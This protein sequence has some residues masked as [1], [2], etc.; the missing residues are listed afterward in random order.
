MPRPLGCAGRRKT[1]EDAFNQRFLD[2]YAAFLQQT[3]WYRYPFRRE[4]VR[5]WRETPWSFRSPVRSAERRF[6]LSLEY[7][8]KALYAVAIGALA[9]AAPAD[10]SIRTVLKGPEEPRVDN[11][12]LVRD[13]GDGT[14]LVQTPRFAAYT[15]ILEAWARI[16]VDVIEIAGNHRILVTAL[17]R[18]DAALDLPGSTPIFVVPIQSRPDWHRIGFDVDVSA[19]TRIIA[20][21][22]GQGATFEHAYDY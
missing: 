11:V 22:A 1:A 9:G 3:P 18:Q 13:L 5:F 15:E 21:S 10:L 19:L 7:G 6:A 2:D 14:R 16:G 20:A 4:L 8:A 17:A 12:I